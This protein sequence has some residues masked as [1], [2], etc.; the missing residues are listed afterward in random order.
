[1]KKL[2]IVDDNASNLKVLEILIKKT[3]IIAEIDT[4][5]NGNQAVELCK[6]NNY[7]II[8]M[9]I[10]MPIMD[11]IEATQWIRSNNNLSQNTPIIVVTAKL[12][13]EQDCN[14]V[15]VNEILWKPVLPKDISRIISSYFE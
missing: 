11:G 13:C 15:G 6:V 8:F 4:A 3:G 1:M 2:L 14:D 5:S 7:A 10:N 9:D 12:F